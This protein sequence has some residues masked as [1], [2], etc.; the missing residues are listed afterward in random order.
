MEKCV[1]NAILAQA[2]ISSYLVVC[3]SGCRRAHKWWLRTGSRP[4]QPLCSMTICINT[5]CPCIEREI[6]HRH[7]R[8]SISVALP[9]MLSKIHGSEMESEWMWIYERL[10]DFMTV[11]DMQSHIAETS[12]L[13]FPF[14]YIFSW[15]PFIHRISVWMEVKTDIPFRRVVNVSQT[16]IFPSSSAGGHDWE[17]ALLAVVVAIFCHF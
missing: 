8:R 1:Y 2:R 11:A 16:F 17:N 5:V 3:S 7:Y 9:Q 10:M 14:F 15:L 12:E 13:Q 4:R 6:H